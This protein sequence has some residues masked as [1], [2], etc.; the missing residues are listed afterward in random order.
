MSAPKGPG[1]ESSRKSESLVTHG[2]SFH[3]SSATR[4]NAPVPET[5]RQPAQVDKRTA[6]V[7]VYLT[8][9][10]KQALANEAGPLSLSS[11]VK[12]LALNQR[13]VILNMTNAEFLI[14]LRKSHIPADRYAVTPKL[15]ESEINH[16]LKKDH[17]GA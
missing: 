9:E 2:V 6:R 8:P 10:E 16:A 17:R 11:Y 4:I 14:L 3:A 5:G 7:I 13:E 12:S 15:I 1:G